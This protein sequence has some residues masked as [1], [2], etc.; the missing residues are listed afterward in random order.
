[1]YGRS[2]GSGNGNGNYSPPV[3]HHSNG[4]GSYATMSGAGG[5]KGSNPVGKV[6]LPHN[7]V[8]TMV[9]NGSSS[10]NGVRSGGQHTS[11]YILSP[12]QG[13]IL[14]NDFGFYR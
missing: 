7:Y 6:K 11:Q 13:P 2:N 4:A 1:M 12:D 3:H 14:K 8:G 5:V 9:G 10:G